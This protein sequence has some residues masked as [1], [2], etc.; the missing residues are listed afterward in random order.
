MKYMNTWRELEKKGYEIRRYRI[1]DFVQNKILMID[2]IIGTKGDNKV[3][4]KFEAFNHDN[5]VEMVTI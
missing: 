1:P 3:I 2:E 4:V 5:M